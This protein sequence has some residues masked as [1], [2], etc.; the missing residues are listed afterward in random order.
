MF[1]L[2]EFLP[3]D[4]SSVIT[5][6]EQAFSESYDS[7]LYYEFQNSWKEGFIVVEKFWKIIGFAVATRLSL[8]EVRLLMLAVDEKYR[9]RGI[10]SAL[11]KEIIKQASLMGINK[12]RLEVKV[13]NKEAI[14]FY[15]RFGFAIAS[16]LP[17]YYNTGEDGFLMLL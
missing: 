15:T 5:L 2:R 3:K 8:N 14:R 6:T 7:S 16:R 9:R 12:I 11:M 17:H 13:N 10:G 4:V 1:R